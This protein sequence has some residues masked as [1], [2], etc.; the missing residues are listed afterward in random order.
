MRRA[1]IL[2]IVLA[3][4]AWAPQVA[5]ADGP[6]PAEAKPKK[7][8]KP[9][10]KPTPPPE[11]EEAPLDPPC[12]PVPTVIC[13]PDRAAECWSCAEWGETCCYSWT[14]ADPIKA[15]APAPMPTPQ[16]TPPPPVVVVAREPVV[17]AV[18][19]TAQGV[20]SG[21]T[22]MEVLP[23]F[24]LSAQGPF[25]GTSLELWANLE[26]TGSPGTTVNLSEVATFKAA[27]F[28]ASLGKRV[29]Y[30]RR[31]GQ[32]V[33]TYLFVE[34]GFATRFPED[35]GPLEKYPQRVVAGLRVEERTRGAWLSLAF[36]RDD[37][38]GGSPWRQLCWRG[39][40]PVYGDA[41]GLAAIVGGKAVLTLFGA[42]DTRDVFVAY[43]GAKWGSQ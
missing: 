30:I 26:L 10:P 41:D 28:S 31:G 25:A 37:I 24:R 34:G 9:A 8:A 21:D 18:V 29:G 22:D 38:A 4:G 16:A 27:E 3:L 40:L 13:G 43:V 1:L 20:V 7:K 15:F 2:G 39:E 32:D 33:R 35:P 5:I 23:G 42:G 19:A 11:T 17:Y 36:G 12:A 6:Y 14:W